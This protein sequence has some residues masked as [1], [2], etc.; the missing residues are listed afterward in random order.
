MEEN[1]EKFGVKSY[2]HYFYE[3]C[4]GIG[5]CEIEQTSHQELSIKRR[6]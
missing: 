4:S 3:D 2:L 5:L 1:S 6:K